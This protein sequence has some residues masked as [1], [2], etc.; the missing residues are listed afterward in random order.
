MTQDMTAIGEILSL[1]DV[2]YVLV[3]PHRGM[4]D[5][6]EVINGRDGSRI[7][8]FRPGEKSAAIEH[9]RSVVD[10]RESF[11]HVLVTYPGRGHE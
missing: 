9:A 7:Q 8:D 10:R 6:L 5:G 1:S 11:D 2:D 3:R 4:K